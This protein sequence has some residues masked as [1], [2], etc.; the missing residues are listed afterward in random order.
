MIT[1]DITNVLDKAPTFTLPTG[2][3]VTADQT[4]FAD[5]QSK[6][7]SATTTEKSGTAE[8]RVVQFRESQTSGHANV[9]ISTAGVIT[10]TGTP[11]VGTITVDW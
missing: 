10:L 8:G 7:L 1:L 3:M 5:G 4:V 6:S 9:E 2:L 11:T